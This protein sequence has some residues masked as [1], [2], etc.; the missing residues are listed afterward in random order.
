[1]WIWLRSLALPQPAAKAASSLV[2][3]QASHW[4]SCLRL[5]P[6]LQHSSASHPEDPGTSTLNVPEESVLI[7]DPVN[8]S[9][10]LEQS[11]SPGFFIIIRVYK[12]PAALVPLHCPR[13]LP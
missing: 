5:M 13:S 6:A 4:T 11:E 1:M 3:V 12:H 8:N 9:L 10:A 2:K 7:Y